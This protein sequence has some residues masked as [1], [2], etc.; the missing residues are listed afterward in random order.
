[1]PHQCC[2]STA[3]PYGPRLRPQGYSL[4]AEG[5]A[6]LA[7]T[8]PH[9]PPHFPPPSPSIPLQEY[10][11]AYWVLSIPLYFLLW[12]GVFYLTHLILH[13]QPVYAASHFRHHAFRPPVA[14]SGIAID[15]IETVFSGI[16]P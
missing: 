16:L 4:E 10:G 1:V 8:P 14:W 12:D 3:R 5:G 7:H 13:W 11:W 9:S 2:P 6:S 15:P